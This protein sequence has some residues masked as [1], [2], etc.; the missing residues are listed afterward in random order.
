MKQFSLEEYLKNPS[1]KVVTRDGRQVRIICTD[2][3]DEFKIVALV[4]NEEEQKESVECFYENGKYLFDIDNH[5]LNLFFATENKDKFEPKTLKPF[6]KVLARFN[7]RFIW[8]C[9]LFSHIKESDSPY[10]FHCIS[11]RWWRCI[12]YNDETKHL[13]GTNDEAPEYYRYWE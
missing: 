1:R 9:D 7:D 3:K 11:G 12:P 8:K 13:V 4:Y 10:I 2:C 6:D 5:H